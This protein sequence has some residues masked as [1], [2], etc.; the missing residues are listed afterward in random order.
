MDHRTFDRLIRLF[1]TMGSRRT[2]WRAL[3]AG[4]LLGATTRRVT[5]EPCHDRKHLCGGACCPGKCFTDKL[6]EVC[7]T[8]RNI[9]CPTAGGPVCCF[10]DGSEDPCA[11][12]RATGE[13]QKTPVGAV[14]VSGGDCPSTGITGSYRRR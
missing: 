13:C 2:A 9:I 8:E 12:V 3:L 4:A 14:S 5:A 10:N 7:C 11:A 1:G 6:C